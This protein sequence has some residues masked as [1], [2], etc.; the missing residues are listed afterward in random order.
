MT[1]SELPTFI[2]H[3]RPLAYRKEA[4]LLDLS[5]TKFPFK[6]TWVEGFKPETVYSNQVINPGET[7]LSFKHY[8]V[9]N[10]QIEDN[11]DYVLYMEDDIDLRS[12]ANVAEFLTQCLREMRD[13]GGELCW[14]GGTRELEIREPK[15][16]GKCVYYHESYTTRCTHAFIVSLDAAKKIVDNYHFHNQVDIMLNGL[17]QTLPIK[18]GWTSPFLYQKSHTYEG[19][20]SSLR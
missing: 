5:E 15:I 13:T 6:T 19:W 11:L 12:I 7:S 1:S 17:I 8:H 9:L 14:V 16:E 10:R 4:L 2:L 18:S 20:R 3:H